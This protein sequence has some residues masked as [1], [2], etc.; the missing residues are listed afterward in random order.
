MPKA[1]VKLPSGT[2]EIRIH[3]TDNSFFT[4]KNGDTIELD[5]VP[6]QQRFERLMAKHFIQIPEAKADAAPP[7]VKG[8]K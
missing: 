1:T 6:S 3:R 7:A 8:K 4:L 2:E 5:D